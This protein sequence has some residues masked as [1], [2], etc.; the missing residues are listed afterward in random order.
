MAI[1]AT[2][3]VV[4]GGTTTIFYSREAAFPGLALCEG[5]GCR[6]EGGVTEV[7]DLAG[8]LGGAL[9]LLFF[10]FITIERVLI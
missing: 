5:V 7:M 9:V 6:G 2:L 8:D 1:G 4:I 3:L 10:E